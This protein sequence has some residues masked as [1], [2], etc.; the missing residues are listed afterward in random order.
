MICTEEP[1]IH[2]HPILHR[3]LIGYLEENTSNQYFVAT[4]S[5]AFIGTLNAGVFHVSNDGNLT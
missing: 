2:L 3:K 5:A 4:H 1:E